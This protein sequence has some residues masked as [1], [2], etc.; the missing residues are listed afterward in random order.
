MS[1]PE[2]VLTLTMNPSVD[3]STSVDEM[4]PNRKLRC[5]EVRYDPGGGGINVSRAIKRLGGDSLAIH[6]CGGSTG[7]NLEKLLDA[8]GIPHRSFAVKE[9]TREDITFLERATGNQYRFVTMG[10]KLSESH[11]KRALAAVR[12]IRPS[13]RLIV[14][15]GSLPP[16][17]P[18]DFYA[19]LAA[20]VRKR[21]GKLILDTSG[22]PLKAAMKAGV[23]LVKP[24]LHEFEELVERK[25]ESSE[26]QATQAMEMVRKG[27]C[28][29]LVL[30]LGKEGAIFA[31][32]Q[33][34]RRFYAPPVMA[35]STVGAGD[36]MVAGITWALSQNLPLQHAVRFGIAAG[37][38]AVINPGTELC[39]RADVEAFFPVIRES[40]ED[41][42]L[43]R[44]AC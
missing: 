23:F 14:A 35:R 17:V 19:Q 16:G 24:S 31:S 13:S 40:F 6:S 43:L 41:K 1:D 18:E 38:S 4:I 27:R 21:D 28:Q 36:S 37:T 11:W 10:P 22:P 3:L 7:E 33:G 44:T 9:N 34:C 32:E 29:A 39:H 15:S 30:S 12:M 42:G 20:I 25:L 2:T 26:D 8:E 5:G